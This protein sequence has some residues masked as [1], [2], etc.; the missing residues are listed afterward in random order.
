MGFPSQDG[1]PSPPPLSLFC[2]LYFF[3]PVFEDNDLLFW[4]PDVLCQHSEVVLWS[5]LSV[6]MF[7]WWICEGESGLPVLFLCHLRTALPSVTSWIWNGRSVEFTRAANTQSKTFSSEV[8]GK[9]DEKVILLGK[10]DKI[11]FR[12]GGT[13]TSSVPSVTGKPE[14]IK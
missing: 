14:S 10:Q 13:N 1:A 3:L 9:L 7:F 4:V 12:S 2:L 5:L 8:I 11:C 6:E